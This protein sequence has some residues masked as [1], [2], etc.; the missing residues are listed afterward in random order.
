[1]IEENSQI[2]LLLEDLT[3]LEDYIH[4]LFVFS[5]LPISFIS[6]IG[7]ILEANPAF[8]RFSQYP[9]E[10]IIGEPAEKIFKKEEIEN[11][12]KETLQ[13]ESVEG[14]E[15]KFFVKEGAEKNVQV[16][17][18]IRKDE[19]GEAVGY[20]LSVFDLTEIKKTEKSLRQAQTALLNI[21]EDTDEARKKAEEEK[22]KTMALIT[23]FVDGLLFFNNRD[24]LA[25]IN[26]QA[27]KIFSI[28]HP[29]IIGKLFTELNEF[30][31]LSSLL[32][33]LGGKDI[34]RL[35]RQELSL[36]GGKVVEVSTIPIMS[37]R[38][39][40]GVLMIIHDITREKLIERTKTEF[41]SL[42]A[43]QLRT[44]L[45]AI[46]W[47]LRMILD[48]DVGKVNREQK[49]FLE[50][51][52]Q[53][54]ER[55]IS[56]I[57]DLLNLARIEEGKYLFTPVLVSLE[58]VCQKVIE[59][60]KE[61]LER[62]HLVLKF[63]QLKKELPQVF[64]DEEKIRFAVE[65]LIDNAIRYT[66]DSGKI[67]ISLREK[68]SGL[69]FQIKDSGVGIPLDQQPRVFS[70][71]FRANNAV[72]METEGSGLGVF[73]AKNIIEAHGGKIWFESKEGEG[74][75]FY[76]SLPFKTGG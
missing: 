55:M 68:D 57:N 76:F 28:D 10:E 15:M 69:E 7:V 49:E 18:K 74:T 48:G 42:A 41:V 71:F 59:V 5:P 33:L 8:E 31:Q 12:V 25:L 4:D 75:T 27:E 37:K 36:P 52:Y 21:L 30:S 67:I 70:K 63:T 22:E 29:L 64:A 1:M 66:P 44:P 53:S 20:F 11:L 60:S 58:N 38:E 46:K 40:L 2:S 45:S 24:R 23:N 62:K 6:P 32:Q 17:T 50:K 47:S 13:K 34:K 35:F 39:K 9:M 26:P 72:R 16:F 54:N 51:S 14:R 43:H 56:L 19:K 73:L 3:A 61:I 65:N